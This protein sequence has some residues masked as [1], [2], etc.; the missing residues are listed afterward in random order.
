MN[1]IIVAFA[2][3]AIAFAAVAGVRL[4]R[5]GAAGRLMVDGKP[6]VVLGGELGNSSATCD[7]DIER[8]FP[9]LARMNLNTV[10][11]PAYWELTEPQEGEFDFA[12][13]D[14]V[15]DEA[16]RNGM[17]VVFLW[18]GV[19]KNSMSCY[20]P[21]WFKTDT[22]R[23]PRARTASGKPLEIAS[24]FSEEVLDADRRAFSRWL[25]HVVERDSDNTVIMVQIEN[26][27]GMLEDARDHSPL[28]EAAFR[29]GVPEELMAYLVKNKKSLHPSLLKKWTEAGGRRSGS[30]T[31]VF[32]DDRYTDEY[33]MAWNY[34]LYVEA[35]ALAAREMTEMPLYVNAAMNSRGRRPGEYPSAGP[36]AHLKDI[37][38]A[39]A[40]TI[41]FLS[42]DIYDSVF[43]EWVAQ[44]ALPDNVLFVPE[45]RRSDANAAQ[46]YYVLGHHDAIGISP[47]SIEGGSDS[48]DSPVV[49]AYSVLRELTP[50]I[51]RYNGSDAMDAVMLSSENPEHVITDGH[52]R[53]TLSHY[54]TLPWDPR[55]KDGSTWPETGGILMKLGEGEYI[56]AGTGIVA[57]FEHESERSSSARLGEDGFLNA[58]ADR[59]NGGEAASTLR[60]GLAKVEEVAVNPDGT[61]SRVRTFNGD[62]THQGRHARIGV[63]DHK[64]LHIKTYN[65]R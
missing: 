56:L 17:K 57:K 22:R 62:E 26:E 45:V 27:I 2:T 38:H 58:G 36:L 8:I 29:R 43:A 4:E 51:A 3:I 6:F 54:F 20:A 18:F 48:P 50:L 7:A 15:M 47:F 14:K 30:W 37:W 44:Y 9:K 31:E 64:I 5:N 59:V 65:Y 61:F 16:R 21:E 10:L 13:T 23:F 60:T 41:D 24:A 55:A 33:F 40:P 11:V 25:K 52:T 1:R 42:P 39:A 63:D 49:A 35:L 32:G 19:W 28:A 12:L 53:I 46:A 34:A